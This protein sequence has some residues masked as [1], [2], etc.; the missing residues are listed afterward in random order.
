MRGFERSL[1]TVICVGLLVVLGDPLLS[2]PGRSN[3]AWAEASD[4]PTE[5]D[6]G[7]STASS[8]ATEADPG[9][10]IHYQILDAR[11]LDL[12]SAEPSSNPSGGVASANTL[13][14]ALGLGRA[15]TE[16]GAAAAIADFAVGWVGGDHPL[17]LLVV[18]YLLTVMLTEMV[19]NNAVAAMLF[20]VAVAV[21]A[22]SG[23][24][25]RPFV[26]AVALAASLSFLT[27]IGYQTNL[28][29]LGPGGYQPRDYLRAGWPLMLLLALTALLLIPQIWPFAL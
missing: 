21:A 10:E 15:L 24:S 3:Q 6:G 13:A 1:L 2:T 11:S 27:P 17:L 23:H 12:S 5:D 4:P 16:S 7:S 19:T 22:A 29:V 20:P 18:M 9:A 8:D 28:M 25:P 14:A 26:M